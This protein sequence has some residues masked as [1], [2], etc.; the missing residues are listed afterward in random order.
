MFE[1]EGAA[2][3]RGR[4]PREAK[5]PGPDSSEKAERVRRCAGRGVV[6]VVVVVDEEDEGT[7]EM[8]VAYGMAGVVVV[9]GKCGCRVVIYESEG[10]G[11]GGL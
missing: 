4:E 11:G 7:G 3:R 6:V 9:A 5:A 8:G 2:R 1:E 10:R